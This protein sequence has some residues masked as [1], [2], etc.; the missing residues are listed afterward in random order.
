MK[1][2][3]VRS[4]LVS[5]VL[6]VAACDDYVAYP[7]GEESAAGTKGV[8]CVMTMGTAQPTATGD[9]STAAADDPME[10]A[11]DE[12][13]ALD[14]FWGAITYDPN[15]APTTTAPDG[16]HM[17]MKCL[18]CHSAG[19]TDVGARELPWAFAGTVR[20][21]NGGP[22]EG[23]VQIGIRSGATLYVTY[24][25]ADGHFWLPTG[26]S[27]WGSVE[28]RMRNAS[29]ERTMARKSGVS[30]DCNACHGPAS[31]NLIAPN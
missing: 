28:I 7:S 10:M 1:S 26:P 17:A 29:G 4:C 21:S 31:Q 3:H 20:R 8:P 19:S 12:G 22:G 24:T 23:N 15:G 14:P 13:A 16:H 9:E 6:F 27:A 30:G 25:S 5:A 18:P 11:G 2:R